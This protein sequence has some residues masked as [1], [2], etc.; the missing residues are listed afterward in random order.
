M[1]PHREAN[2]GNSSDVPS[3]DYTYDGAG[4][5]LTDAARHLYASSIGRANLPWKLQLDAANAETAA[6]YLYDAADQRIFKRTSS[7]GAAPTEAFHLR[8]AS[9]RELGVLDTDGNTSGWSWYAFAHQRFAKVT[10]QQQPNP[11]GAQGGGAPFSYVN[12]HPSNSLA[13]PSFYLHDHWGNMRVA[14]T[15]GCKT[16]PGGAPVRELTLVHAADYAPYGSVLREYVNT[17]KERY[18]TTQHERDQETGLDYRGARYYD[19]DVG[20]FLSLDP[21]AKQYARWTPYCFVLGNPISLIDP[22]GRG[23]EESGWNENHKRLL[24]TF[25]D[26]HGFGEYIKTHIGFASVPNER[27]TVLNP[28]PQT[29]PGSEVFEKSFGEY[30]ESR[31]SAWNSEFQSAFGGIPYDPAGYF[32]VLSDHLFEANWPA[33][34]QDESGRPFGDYFPN[35]TVQLDLVTGFSSDATTNARLGDHTALNPHVTRREGDLVMNQ[36]LLYPGNHQ[37]VVRSTTIRIAALHFQFIISP[38]Q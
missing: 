20:R 37:A 33:I 17:R 31:N 38:L 28:S 26:N 21:L 16:E 11:N 32:D 36:G 5:L 2:T 25:G 9:G 7:S 15:A 3:R 6:R 29:T 1:R 23:A 27:S 19:G 12:A 22:T 14:Y 30:L 13:E 24:E 8:D 4:N 35:H 18:L 10:L 34:L